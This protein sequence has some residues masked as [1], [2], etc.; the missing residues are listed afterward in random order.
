MP[1]AGGPFRK[2]IEGLKRLLRR[3]PGPELPEDPYAYVTAP[4]KPPPSSRAAAA[5]ADHPQE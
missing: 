1:A 4:R 2:M 3:K 5:V